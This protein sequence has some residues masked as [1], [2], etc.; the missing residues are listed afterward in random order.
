MS[1]RPR[2]RYETQSARR[3]RQGWLRAGVWVF[4]FVFAFS[5]VGGLLAI[6]GVFH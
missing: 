2:V 1:Q 4:I 5:I 3:R 6:G